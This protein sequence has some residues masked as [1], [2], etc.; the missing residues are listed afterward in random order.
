MFPLTRRLRQAVAT[1]VLLALTVAPTI[2][3]AV[4]AWRINRP[5]HVRDVEIE[6][7]RQLGFQVTQKSPA[8]TTCGLSGPTAS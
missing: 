6:L 5:G 4:L 1:V 2:Y 8:P 7:R 3:I